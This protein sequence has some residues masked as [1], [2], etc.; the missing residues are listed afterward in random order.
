MRTF[1]P[2]LV[3]LCFILEALALSKTYA[4]GTFQALNF[5]ENKGQ[6]DKRALF[7]C[8]LHIGDLYLE[9]NG[10]TFDMYSAKELDY[11]Y[12][13]AHNKKANY[14]PK[15]ILSKHAYKMRFRGANS[16]PVI[17]SEGRVEGYKNYFIGNDPSKWASQVYSYNLVRYKNLYEN[18]DLEI[19]TSVS[20][21]KYDYIVKKGA[22]PHSIQV[23]YEGVKSLKIDEKGFLVIFLSNG[24]VK[25]SKPFAY[26]KIGGEQV[27]VPCNY[28]LVNNVVSFEFPEGYNKSVDLI[29]DPVL[30]FSSLTGSTA[31][32]WGFTAT[33]DSQ[34]N[35]YGGGIAFAF[36][37]PVTTG[38]YQTTFAGSRDIT[39]SKFNATGNAL[40]FS[41]YLGGSGA[42]VPHSLVNDSQDNL[43]VMGSTGSNNYPVTAGCYDNT[44]N[45]GVNFT[46]SNGIPYTAGADAII[47]KF[48]A[49]GTVLLGSTYVGGTGNDGISQSLA[50]NYSDE[51][52][53]EVVVDNL[54]NIYVT[55]STRST[56][57]PTTPG[58]HSQTNFGNQDA[59]VFKMNPL[60]TTLVWSTYFGGTSNDAGYSI[61]VAPNNNV[62]I[63]GGTTSN[64][65]GTTVGALMPTFNG[66]S[67]DGYIA[68]FDG[69]TGSLIAAT[70]IGTNSY[71][72][73]FILEVDDDGDVY[74]VGQTKGIYPI[75][76]A[77]Y[78]VPN[79]AQFIHK[80][81]G[82][83]TSTIFST[84]FGDGNRTTVDVSLTAF[85]VDDCGN[86]YVSGWGGNINTEGT[87]FGLPVTPNAIKTTTDG[88][89]FYFIVIEKNSTSL[90]YGS[91]F[92]SNSIAEHVDGGTSRFDK[93]GTIYQAACAGC[94]GG[95]TFPTTPGVWSNNNGSTNCNLG[96][97]KISFDFQG[98]I[99][100]AN[101]PPNIMLCSSPYTVNFNGNTT[102]PPHSYWNFGDGVGSSTAN[103]P[104]YTYADTG[105]YTVMYVVIDSASCN[106]ADTVYLNVTLIQKEEFDA[107]F[108][109][110]S[111]D[112][113][114]GLDSLPVEFQFTGTG[115]DSLIWVMGDGTI[116]TN[117]DS[118][119]YY[120]TNTGVYTVMLIAFDTIC[121]NVDTLTAT[122]SYI[123]NYT[124]AVADVPGDVFLCTTP[125]NVDFSAGPNPPPHNYWDFGDGAGTSTLPAITY[126]YQSPG[127][128]T[129][130]YVAIDSTTCNIADTAYFTVELTQ[131]QQF[132]AQF[133]FQPP[134]VC[135]VDSMLVELHFTGSGAD[136]IIWDMGN[137]DVF[138]TNSVSYFFSQ[139]GTYTVSMT[140]IDTACN[141]VET[142]VEQFTFLGDVASEAQIPNIF[143]PNGDGKNDLL[144]ILNVDYTETY[145]MRIYN[146]WGTKVFETENT[147]NAWNGKTMSG[148]DA[149]EGVYFYELIY[150]D[151]CSQEE[152]LK[153]GFIH[154]VR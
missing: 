52:R 20:Q 153:T 72:Q 80:L 117:V 110:P 63:C 64:N 36:G 65:I 112:P 84:L 1:S 78:S 149:S 79:S 10:F 34:G 93:Q 48:N 26:Q 87:T 129:V 22:N 15:D 107:Q 70:Y 28:L 35:V 9:N 154:L 114:D 142:I 134:P 33:Y 32:N 141:N 45:G 16:S 85:L 38:A 76:N 122:V 39:I 124:Q 98:V 27:E 133:D 113:C 102:P 91:Y 119:S 89:D 54:N 59:V 105:S 51:A 44:F 132:A 47:T 43:I 128:Y 82:N 74:T 130:M 125:L 66:G 40:L 61:R 115:A 90:L 136:S 126:T 17:Q 12:E 4:H 18:I 60:L 50:F 7:H 30:V 31:D 23:G 100:Q 24:E 13:L 5:S 58:S 3:L 145:I 55:C 29:I 152:K 148:N 6:L 97:I 140:A 135:G 120:Y 56:N 103:N 68:A 144:T 14:T 146:R 111:V 104:S 25:E 123:L 151:I 62:Y 88:S 46:G 137:G 41:T 118:V 67:H 108:N 53:G 150:K 83:L 71:D 37:Y 121:N 69:N 101:V 73:A 95:Q 94:G 42:D 8:K 99:A 11:Y 116:F 86:I 92:G 21:I 127:T 49:T 81:N 106:V 19:Y 143:S 139:P 138:Y 75:V 131:A 77:P 109:I 2:L 96:A 147:P 57:F